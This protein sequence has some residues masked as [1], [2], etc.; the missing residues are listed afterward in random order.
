MTL[1]FALCLFVCF[2]PESIHPFV[3]FLD[4]AIAFLAFYTVFVLFLFVTSLTAT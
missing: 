1:F 3:V 4:G 2:F